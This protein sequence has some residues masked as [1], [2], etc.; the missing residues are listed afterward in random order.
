MA[1]V[2]GLLGSLEDLGQ[3]EGLS[4]EQ[5]ELL[6]KVEDDDGWEKVEERNSKKATEDS[7][8]AIPKF[9]LANEAFD[10]DEKIEVHHGKPKHIRW[11]MDEEPQALTAQK[12]VSLIFH[13][14]Q[15]KEPR[16][17]IFLSRKQAYHFMRRNVTM[18]YQHVRCACAESNWFYF[19]FRSSSV[20]I[21][22]I[23]RQSLRS[24]PTRT[25]CGI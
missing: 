15:M 19:V 22:W 23:W 6:K 14:L 16:I 25:D 9:T 5:V 24:F 13:L 18:R 3:G 12:Q 11:E 8:Q 4:Q 21:K 2:V 10:E 7:P 20:W 17:L 1:C